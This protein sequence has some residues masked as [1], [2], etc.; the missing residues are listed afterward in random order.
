MIKK[1]LKGADLSTYGFLMFSGG[2]ERG[3]LRT[4]GFLNL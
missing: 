4:N 1:V 2:G 3:A